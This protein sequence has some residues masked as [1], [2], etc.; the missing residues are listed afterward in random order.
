M[1]QIN[2]EYVPL[3][4]L[5]YL[6]ARIPTDILIDL[7][8]QA[9]EMLLNNFQD[10]ETYNQGLY[11]AIENE[12]ILPNEQKLSSYV[13]ELC[14]HF[15]SF[16]YNNINANKKHTLRNTWINFQKKNE[17]NPVHNHDGDLSFVV[18]LKIPYDLE[19]E[20]NVANVKNSKD[21]HN[22]TAGFTFLYSV[23]DNP[24]MSGLTK[25]IIPMTK[26]REGEI[27]LFKSNLPHMVY[28]F[29]TSD[30]YRISIS[31]NIIIEE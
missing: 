30:E 12:F 23:Y 5:G 15:W 27:V 25:H 2:L 1:E 14:K 24:D 20:K 28:P 7:N 29:Y 21:F 31:G 11:G 13:L 9:N 26:N 10:T 17:H 18:W 19:K 6:K 22:E 16:E 8:N 3:I 4:N